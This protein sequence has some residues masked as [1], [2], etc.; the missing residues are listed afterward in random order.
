MP[1]RSILPVGKRKLSEGL[2]YR[3]RRMINGKWIRSRY[4]FLTAQDAASAEAEAVQKFMMTGQI[5]S[6][7]LNTSEPGETIHD[8]L[9][10]RVQWLRDHRSEHHARDNQ[11]LFQQLFKYSPHWK[12]MPVTDLR[13]DDVARCAERWAADLLTRGK[14]RYTVNKALINLQSAFNCPWESRRA[15]R[16]YPHNPFAMMERFSVERKAKRIPSIRESKKVLQAAPAGE[17][18]LYLRIQVETGARPG[19]ARKIKISDLSLHSP[20][21]V[22][23]TRKKRGGS[24]TPRRVPISKDFAKDL[25]GWIRKSENAVYL[26]QQE[27][28]ELPRTE[29][30]ALNLQMEACEKAK[31]PY[32]SLHG[33]RHWHASKLIKEK[34]M[35]LVQIKERLGHESISTTD[36]YIHELV[37][38]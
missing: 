19:E 34:R 35:S 4:V 22:L 15:E 31:V 24:L 28:R 32:F 14:S 16:I 38:I 17:K 5:P 6:G 30:W 1:W 2:R 25:K 13:M 20:S 10:R 3:Y 12:D 8:L 18:R 36:K 23:Y 21:V 29:R 27:G 11:Y 33:W 37:G 9:T 26:F 7:S